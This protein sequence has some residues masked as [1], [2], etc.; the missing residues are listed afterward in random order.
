MQLFSKYQ[1]LVKEVLSGSSLR[2][3][4]LIEGVNK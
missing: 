3:E 1:S 4:K 2:I